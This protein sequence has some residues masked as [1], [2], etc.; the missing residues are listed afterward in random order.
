MS[1][2]WDFGM[3]FSPSIWH[4][5]MANGMYTF[6][7]GDLK[8]TINN[9]NLQKNNYADRAKNIDIFL[10]NWDKVTQILNINLQG[11]FTTYLTFFLYQH[12][13]QLPYAGGGGDICHSPLF[14][15]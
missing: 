3:L 5:I 12:L 14:G 9:A 10:L 8:S 7:P 11:N 15:T 2:L 1:F 6:T 4:P 13:G